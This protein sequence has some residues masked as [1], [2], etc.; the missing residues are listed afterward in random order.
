MLTG[1]VSGVMVNKSVAKLFVDE[2]NH[3]IIRICN[4]SMKTGQGVN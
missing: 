2:L 3:K 1:L 4:E